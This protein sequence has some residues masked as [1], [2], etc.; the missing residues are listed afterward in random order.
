M[1]LGDGSCKALLGTIDCIRSLISCF[2]I[3]LSSGQL[4]GLSR[5]LLMQGQRSAR[6]PGEVRVFN[7]DVSRL[8]VERVN[9]KI[10]EYE[11]TDYVFD[12]TTEPCPSRDGNCG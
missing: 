1:Q 5:R 7:S 2:K 11:W 12:K 8:A 6:V 9:P 10:G 4:L 3:C